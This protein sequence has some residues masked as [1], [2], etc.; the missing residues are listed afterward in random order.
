MYFSFIIPTLNEEEYLPALLDDIKVQTHKD[1][2]VV[3][4]DAD[5]K[6]KTVK[7]ASQYRKDYPIHVLQ[8]IT[9]G[10]A[11][12]R[13][14]GAFQAEGTY[15]ICIDADSRIDRDF[16]K[17][18]YA[19]LEEKKSLIALPRIVPDDD[20]LIDEAIFQISNYCVEVSQ[21]IGKPVPTAGCMIF[22]RDFFQHIGGYDATIKSLSEDHE[23]LVRSRAAGVVADC[24]KNVMVRFSMRRF[25]KEGR[26]AVMKAYMISALEMTIKGKLTDTKTSDNYKMGGH[27]FPPEE[28]NGHSRQPKV[29]KDY[30]DK[31]K[32]AF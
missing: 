2:E 17:G 15:V 21:L 20:S 7:V 10:P 29:I 24:M 5:S 13:N 25:K 12:Q 26:L 18:V 22:Q 9:K 27:F 30:I 4:I 31:L 32:E 14:Q 23:I 1:F 28:E 16:L 8:A 6:D 11:A 19:H 3:I